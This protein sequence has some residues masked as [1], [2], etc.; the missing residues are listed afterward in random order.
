MSENKIIYGY[1]KNEYGT[2]VFPQD[3][4]H[5]AVCRYLLNNKCY[6]KDMVDFVKNNINNESMIHAGTFIGDMLPA[7]S[8][9]TDGKIY[10]FEPVAENY[11]FA[12]I[13]TERNSLDNVILKNNA[14]SDSSQVLKMKTH[15]NGKKHGGGSF[16]CKDGDETV[17][18]IK[19][20]DAVPISEKI[21]IIQLDVEGYE[22]QV[23]SGAMTTIKRNLPILIVETLPNN[24]ILQVLKKLGYLVTDS[25]KKLNNNYCIQLNS[26]RCGKIRKR[27]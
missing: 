24:E 19:I 27:H 14:L 2:Y 11:K 23:I 9:F 8:S 13:N 3:L 17:D 12:K 21:S 15:E 7:F 10:A 22:S 25:Y 5:R 4:Q 1:G 20:D 6:E 26:N 18:A 16:V